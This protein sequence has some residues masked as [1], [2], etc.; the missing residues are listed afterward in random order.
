MDQ[1]YGLSIYLDKMILLNRKRSTF[2]LS[3]LSIRH[4]DPLV[5]GQGIFMLYSGG[6]LSK[7]E[8]VPNQPGSRKDIAQVKGIHRDPVTSPLPSG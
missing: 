2:F 5:Y 3:S 8:E 7:S 6:C 1:T 4:K